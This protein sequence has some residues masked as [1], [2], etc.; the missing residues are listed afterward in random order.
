MEEKSYIY[1]VFA[2]LLFCTSSLSAAIAANSIQQKEA[3]EILDETGVKGGLIVHI[4]CEDGKLTAALCTNDGY[5]VHGLEEDVQDVDKAREYIQSLGMYG[6][7][8]A[9]SFDGERLPYIDN[10]V[11]LVVVGNLGDVSMDEVRRVLA[12]RGV[13]Y[14]QREGKWTKFAKPW[15]EQMDE[16]TH[17]LHDPQG[18]MVGRDEIVALPRRLQWV[19]GP[20]WLR[21]HDFMSSLSGL[22]SSGGRIFYIIDEG[23]RNH[24][25]LPARWAVVARDAFNGKILWKRRI[26][27]W[28]PHTWPFKSGPGDLP[29]RIVAVGDKVYVTLGL[30]E[31]LS[32]LDAATGET[33]RT[34]NQTKGTEEIVLAD[35]VLYLVVDTDK[36]GM[37]YKHETDNRGKERDRAN[38]EFGWSMESPDRVIMAIPA[39]ELSA[40][41]GKVLWR[42]QNNI[43]P[44]TLAVQGQKV[45]FY[46]GQHIVALNR[47]S[48]K[49]EWV[50]ETVAIAL[51][52]ATG[53]APRLIAGKDVIV[54]STKGRAKG[55]LRKGGR[56]VGVSSASGKILWRAEQLNSGHFSPED[57]FLID[58]VVWT[59]QT[60]KA[61]QKGTHFLGVDVRTG[62]TKHYFVAEQIQASFMH[63]RCYPGRATERYIMTSGTGTEFLELGTE[64]CDLNHWLRGSCIYGI[65]PCNGLIYRPPETCACYYQSKLAHFCALAPEYS[66]RSVPSEVDVKDRLIHGPAYRE[67]ANRK[68]M[69]KV[70]KIYAIGIENA[71]SWPT[72]RHDTERS[73]MTKTTV[74]ADL[75]EMWRTNIGGRLSTIT[76]ADGKIFIS[77][78]DQHTIHAITADTGEKIWS[79]TTGGRVDSPPTIHNGL[80]IFGCAD[81]WVY[82]L[83]GSD[84]ELAWRYR[85]APAPDKLVSYQQVESVWPLHGS[86]LVYDDVVY[87]LAGRNMFVDG[88]MRLV[89]LDPVTGRLLSETVMDDKDPSTGKNLQTLMARKAVPV[90]NS[91]ILSCDG[92]YIYMK[93][94]KFDLAGRRVDIEIADGKQADQ[95]GDGRHLFCP[96]G[97]LDDYW[98]HRSYWIYGKNAGE[99]HGEYIVPRS[100]TQVGRLMVFDEESVYSFFAQNVGNNIN[101]RTYYSLYAAQKDLVEPEKTDQRKT[102]RRGRKNEPAK[103]PQAKIQ[104]L[105]EFARPELLANAMVLAGNNLF[106][107]GPPD[108]ADE[109]KTREYVF[110]ADD[111]I[112]RQM[113]RQEQAWLGE[114]GALLWAVSAD[115]GEKLSR[116]KIPA[117]PVWDGMIAANGRLYLALD[118]GSV[119]CMGAER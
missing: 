33:I 100:R 46:D 17:Y 15:P 18:T 31:P 39:A 105:W 108:V 40:D 10:L 69:P 37:L 60:G 93:S 11:N 98:F 86:V 110:G 54:L 50:S 28:F 97:F 84:G 83:R 62:K 59:A 45:F 104:R 96:T 24:I 55:S 92:K 42:H 106:I 103:E 107:A 115:T 99:G 80:V 118:D 102:N 119:L 56:L 117:I 30:T 8:S 67:I 78:K 16:W 32:V 58:G 25:Y 76:A 61:Q 21:N 49:E 48:G 20:K 1:A 43:A 111:R 52:P 38:R 88:G 90:T 27:K 94:Q 73:G 12:P 114:Q 95:V 53:Y 29:R 82:C 113:R 19:A 77:A 13:A 9:D 44:L 65:M 72:Y 87:C 35:G 81:G 70:S 5:L 116:H 57:V 101:P 71:D 91:D 64:H 22:V 34:Y 7:V 85:A 75:Q 26:D 63:Q 51:T 66:G 47:K 41:T 23:L 3:R 36:E 79:Y 2:A 14:I 74:S 112:N 109:E 6:K 4:G 89:R 68:F